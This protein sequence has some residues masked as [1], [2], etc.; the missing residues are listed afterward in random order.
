MKSILLIIYVAWAFCLC[1]IW[2]HE[3]KYIAEILIIFPKLL[4]KISLILSSF[5]KATQND[6]IF[7]AT[8]KNTQ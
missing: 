7:V 1:V 5:C 3:I 2:L 8:Q 6:N 4:I